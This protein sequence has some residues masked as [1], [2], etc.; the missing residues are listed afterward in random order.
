MLQATMNL[1]DKTSKLLSI[2]DMEVAVLVIEIVVTTSQAAKKDSDF[3]L[4]IPAV[5]IK[6]EPVE[7]TVEVEWDE[8]EAR[9]EE[10][11][12]FCANFHNT[13]I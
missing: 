8:K 13:R 10:S 5:K 1:I 7:V 6:V 9:I 3:P 12:D 11:Q 2:S 4:V